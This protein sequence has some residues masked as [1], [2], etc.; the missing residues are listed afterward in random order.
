MAVSRTLDVSKLEWVQ[1]ENK[2]GE[3]RAHAIDPGS[4]ERTGILRTIT[5]AI[6]P[7]DAVPAEDATQRDG[8]SLGVVERIT[9][10]QA[11]VDAEAAE[12]AKAK[13]ARAA[14]EAEKR[15]AR[16]AEKAAKAEARA[17]EAQKRAEAKV[18]AAKA[19]AEAK[20]AKE[21][22]PKPERKAKAEAIE[23]AAGAP[24]PSASLKK[25]KNGKNFEVRHFNNGITEVLGTFPVSAVVEGEPE[26]KVHVT[27]KLWLVMQGKKRIAQ[28]KREAA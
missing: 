9:Q 16:E 1:W 13:E 2:R 18:E 12:K 11:Q 10:V 5:G 25:T 22:Q 27:D 6:V 24:P 7:K 26:P 21:A 15:Q 23:K 28:G 17:A 4:V 8:F 3:L 14:A 19:R 20:A